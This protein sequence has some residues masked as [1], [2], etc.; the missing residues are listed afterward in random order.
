MKRPGEERVRL[1]FDGKL[2]GR[3]TQAA[4]IR[5]LLAGGKLKR[6]HVT[7]V[8]RIVGG[9]RTPTLLGVPRESL[10][11][12]SVPLR[13]ERTRI[14]GRN[15]EAVYSVLAR[16]EFASAPREKKVCKKTCRRATRKT[17]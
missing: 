2:L 13:L 15:L 17:S 10:L 4:R 1:S 16:G 5:E 8:P 6:L 3:P 11:I 7:F 9:A 12:K 14:I